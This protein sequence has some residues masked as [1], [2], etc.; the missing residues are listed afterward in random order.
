MKVLVQILVFCGL[1]AWAF[2]QGL[3]PQQLQ[4]QF[5]AGAVSRAPLAG[6][7]VTAAGTVTARSLAARFAAR[8][9]VLDF[10]AAGNGQSDDTSAFQ[11]AEEWGR[12]NPGQQMIWLDPGAYKLTSTVYDPSGS[13]WIVPPGASVSGG[14]LEGDT[15]GSTILPNHQGLALITKANAPGGSG[16]F[17]SNVATGPSGYDAYETDGLYVNVATS[18]PSSNAYH[19]MVAGHFAAQIAPGNRMGRAWGQDVVTT[20]P[21]NADG[22]AIG[23]EITITNNSSTTGNYGDTNAKFGLS[24]LAGG[25]SNTTAAVLVHDAG[26]RFADGI[27]SFATAVRDSFLRL[28]NGTVDLAAIYADGSALLGKTVFTGPVQLQSVQSSALPASCIPGQEIYVQDGR[29]PGENAGSGTGTVAFCNKNLIWF[30][31]S[32]GS[33]VAH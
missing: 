33:P 26:A 17:V 7:M 31:S 20:V 9:S 16:L 2:A 1:P 21:A 10:G 22:Y 4:A 28:K 30:A 8:P 23:E 14:L 6:Q 24:V 12:Y 15:D 29:N 3:T 32:S 13:L 25:N 19:D 5:A 27:L 18:D 11:R